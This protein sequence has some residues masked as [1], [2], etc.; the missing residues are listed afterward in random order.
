MSQID[1]AVAQG[2]GGKQI[3]EAL[4]KLRAGHESKLRSCQANLNTIC[5]RAQALDITSTADP[6]ILPDP[7][8]EVGGVLAMAGTAL[9]NKAAAL[10][11]TKQI[12]EA[13][14]LRHGLTRGCIAPSVLQ[15]IL[16]LAILIVIEGLINASFFQNAAM[17]ASPAAALLTSV[18][19]SITNITLSTCAGY[20]IGRYTGYGANAADSGDPEFK[21]IRLRA[22]ALFW[23]FLAVMAVF[24][25]TVGL[26]RATESLD[27][28]FH[29]PDSYRA[30]IT[31]PEAFFLVLTGACLSL[32]AYRKG[33][34][35]FDDPY[36]GYGQ[37]HRAVLAIED[38]I[39]DLHEEFAGEIEDCFA[40]G[41]KELARHYKKQQRALDKY[42]KVVGASADAQRKLERAISTAESELRMEVAQLASAHRSTRGRKSS[43]TEQALDHL[44]RFEGYLDTPL[45]VY[46][47]GGPDKSAQTR[48]SKCKSDAL[49]R[50][51]ILFQNALE[52]KEESA[53]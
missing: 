47:T 30:L 38:E 29:D 41:E 50:L 31:T 5:A 34:M 11:R 21:Y 44:V 45:P 37:R 4:Y 32:L 19:I 53:Q 22:K 46:A 28:I 40:R 8:A 17:T 26:I 3:D 1:W 24:H 39:F 35:S 7:S 43:A 18:L 42:N 15:S 27:H 25:A 10:E 2:V 33:K 51:S 12:E 9:A 48:L 49:S 13:F 16:F 36:P 52:T 6:G 14:R 23:C 20:F